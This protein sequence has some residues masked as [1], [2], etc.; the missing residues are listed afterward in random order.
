MKKLILTLSCLI[1]IPALA[2]AQQTLTLSTFYPS[3]FGV[4]NILRLVPQAADP[5][6]AGV[7]G[8][9]WVNAQ[10]ELRMCFGNNPAIPPGVWEQDDATD[11]I[12]VTD[13]D[14]A[15]ANYNANLRVGIGTVAPSS[16]FQVHEPTIN[17]ITAMRLTTQETGAAA[18]G[19]ELGYNSAAA[20]EL[21]YVWNYENT[22]L[23]FGTNNLDRMRIAA[24]GRVGIGTANPSMLLNVAG[25]V[26]FNS[27]LYTGVPGVNRGHLQAGGEGPG[28][29]LGG[30]LTLVMADDWDVPVSVFDHWVVEI[31]QNDF[32][33]HRD[34]PHP[35][36]IDMKINELG[37]VG[38]GLSGDPIGS[39]LV[40]IRGDLMV[41]TTGALGGT[42]RVT[43]HL[44]AYVSDEKT[45]EN[46]HPTKGLETIMKLKGVEFDW[47][48]TGE[49][50][51]GLIAQDVEKVLP[52]LV[53]T[54]SG[55]DLKT[56]QY[57]N[58]VAPLIEAIK[59]QQY[60]IESLKKELENLKAE[61]F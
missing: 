6:C 8:L 40:T 44:F 34:G 23:V 17:A 39:N 5:A 37:Q 55:T 35:G 2:H 24:D 53:A 38:F 36:V 12:Y 25:D 45:K 29:I 42:G 52:D 19:L 58:L 18:D 30:R 51:I 59:E 26:Q 15:S 7:D 13:L 1:L 11:S 60:Q 32:E 50:G 54:A 16:R 28:N 20:P 27:N 49:K 47:V 57:G 48:G 14:P 31:L 33:I 21:A 10:G 41:S 22:P 46:V 43:A 56:V 9:L 4:Y 3:P 61:Q